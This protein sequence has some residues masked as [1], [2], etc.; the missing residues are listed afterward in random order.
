MANPLEIIWFINR[1][2]LAI[3]SGVVESV[4]I[5]TFMRNNTLI[6]EIE[7]QVKTKINGIETYKRIKEDDIF[8]SYEEAYENIFGILPTPSP[9][10]TFGIS[11]TPTPT[12]TPTPTPTPTPTVTESVTP[13][14][15]PSVT[16]SPSPE[17]IDE[18]VWVVVEVIP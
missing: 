14:P 15:T 3:Y 2:T 11:P 8:L 18:G 5:K 16:P 10:N 4:H 7:Y 9:T 1:A 12:G 17:V 6:D 13:T